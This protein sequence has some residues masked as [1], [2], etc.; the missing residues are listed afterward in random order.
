MGS[1]KSYRET[2]ENRRIPTPKIAYH[3]LKFCIYSIL[4]SIKNRKTNPMHCHEFIRRMPPKISKAYKYAMKHSRMKNT[5]HDWNFSNLE[6]SAILLSPTRAQHH[7]CLGQ[8]KMVCLKQYNLSYLFF[9]VVSFK[10]LF[11]LSRPLLKLAPFHFPVHLCLPLPH[12]SAPIQSLP[13]TF[14]HPRKES[15]PPLPDPFLRLC[16]LG[17]LFISC[18]GCYQRL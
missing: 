7:T 15:L 8:S 5:S 13:D 17:V 16:I 4:R 12:F 14:K 3:S 6:A 11:P 18:D 10:C 9:M 1:L 2:I